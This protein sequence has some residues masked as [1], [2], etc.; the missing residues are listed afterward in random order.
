[1][2]IIY[3]HPNKSGHCG[4]ILNQLEKQLKSDRRSY[5]ILD[6]YAVK[7]NPVLADREHPS[8]EKKFIAPEVRSM[9]KKLAMHDHLIVIYP[10]WWNSMPAILKGFF[11]RVLTTGFAF[12]FKNNHPHGLLKGKKAFAITSMGSPKWLNCLLMGNRVIKGVANDVLGFCG[13]KTNFAIVDNAHHVTPAQ[14]KK[15]AKITQKAIDFF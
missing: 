14:H 1:M 5:E 4:A 12:E 15:I 10:T 6:L 13:Y 9:Q 2:L 3:A 7:F 8:A 11:D